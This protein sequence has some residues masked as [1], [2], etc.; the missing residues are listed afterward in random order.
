MKIVVPVQKTEIK[1]RGD[2]PRCPRDTP[3][4]AKVG[5][6]FADQRRS[7]VGIVRLRTNGHGVR[8]YIYSSARIYTHRDR[9]AFLFGELRSNA[10]L[11]S[12][13]G[14][15]N[16]RHHVA[17]NVHSWRCNS[18]RSWALMWH[19]IGCSALCTR[20]DHLFNALWHGPGRA[21]LC[22]LR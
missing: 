13:A 17:R 9:V 21:V 4:S 3:L 20:R 16:T 22:S 19:W 11:T 7:L 15:G 2:P 1:G 10:V 12:D 8:L 18:N 6:K 14:A 5:T